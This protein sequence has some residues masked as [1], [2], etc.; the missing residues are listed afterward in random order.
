M[1]EGV[2]WRAIQV[3]SYL[4]STQGSIPTIDVFEVGGTKSLIGSEVRMKGSP[5]YVD[6]FE[7]KVPSNTL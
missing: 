7:D 4:V 2:D 1:L 3:E 5:C 6:P